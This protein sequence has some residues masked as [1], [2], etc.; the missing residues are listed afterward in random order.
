MDF[1][2]FV[3][4]Q[5]IQFTRSDLHFHAG[6]APTGVAHRGAISST[7]T[8]TS[9]D[10]NT[11]PVKNEHVAGK[12]LK[13]G[14]STPSLRDGPVVSTSSIAL[15][16]LPVSKS[17]AST[18]SYAPG[19]QPVSTSVA[20]TSS[21]AP[22]SQPVST[23]VA[24]TSSFAPGSQPVSTSVASTSSYAAGSQPASTSVASTSSF[25]PGS[26]PSLP[27]DPDLNTLTLAPEKFTALNSGVAGSFLDDPEPVASTSSFAPGSLPDD[28]ESVAS[29]SLAAEDGDTSL[30]SV[31][32]S[33]PDDTDAFRDEFLLARDELDWDSVIEQ[34]RWLEQ[35]YGLGIKTNLNDQTS[36]FT[37]FEDFT[38]AV[39]AK[40]QISL[41][42]TVK[43]SP[44]M[45]TINHT[46]RELL[47]VLVAVYN[48]ALPYIIDHSNLPR[49]E[50][51]PP[52][53]RTAKR[54][55]RVIVSSDEE[56]DSSPVTET[57]RKKQ[58]LRTSP[59]GG[60]T[61]IDYSETALSP[62]LKW[63]ETHLKGSH[64]SPPLAKKRQAESVCPSIFAWALRLSLPL[65]RTLP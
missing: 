29:T 15:G 48:L 58:R 34:S 18:S 43:L 24:S 65:Q 50:D 42:E 26:L 63:E 55:A 13:R 54:R 56:S 25:A 45:P 36:Y 17:V 62:P 9:R 30:P 47:Y 12:N 27:D 23:S 59:R 10:V 46:E 16:S 19:S 51:T 40:L 44:G 32:F 20:S 49:S 8:Y 41:I 11:S 64:I 52:P 6:P 31:L 33:L 3:T 57:P 35:K 22:G 60:L 39:D 61:R 53:P 21:N 14:A 37:L 5:G 4:G 2:G 28:T 38:N 1:D 7:C